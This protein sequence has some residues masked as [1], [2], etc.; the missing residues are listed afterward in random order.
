MNID[1]GLKSSI[2]H[3]IPDGVLFAI[4]PLIVRRYSKIVTWYASGRH[5]SAKIDPFELIHVNPADIKQR[6]LPSGKSQFPRSLLVSDVVGGDWDTNIELL[7]NYDLIASIY[8]RF[9]HNVRWEHTDFYMRVKSMF[10]EGGGPKW[11]CD[12]MDEFSDRLLELE[13]LHE[14]IS[15]HGF[16]SQRELRATYEDPPAQRRIHQFWPPELLEVTVNISRDGEIMLDDGRHRLSIAQ[17][18]G[19]ESIPVRVRVR[20]SIWQHYRDLVSEDSTVV[21]DPNHPDILIK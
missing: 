16:L 4:Y 17:T 3:V 2:N 8:D 7:E 15:T 9:N 21:E 11:G 13:Q 12:N 5:H 14:F 19:I 18:V 6:V 20:H 10:E 1:N